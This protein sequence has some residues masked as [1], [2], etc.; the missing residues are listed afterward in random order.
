MSGV[1]LQAADRRIMMPSAHFMMHHGSIGVE[2]TSQIVSSTVK[3]NDTACKQMTDIFARRA[4]NGEFAQE[5][6]FDVKKLARFFDNKL[7]DTT[8][9]YLTAEEAV[10]YGL[11][12]EVYKRK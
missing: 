1:I 7:K 9:W 4:I 8:D 2:G 10:Y 3:F 11:A 6:G 12:D 5:K